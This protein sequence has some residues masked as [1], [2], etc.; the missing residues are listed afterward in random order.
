MRSVGSVRRRAA[1]TAGRVAWHA[2]APL[3]LAGLVSFGCP[4]GAP[5]SPEQPAG[6]RAG[7]G[8]ERTSPLASP[9]AAGSGDAAA[10]AASEA[11]APASPASAPV[12]VPPALPE[13]MA[14]LGYH[15]ATEVALAEFVPVPPGATGE[16]G[17]FGRGESTVRVA[18]VR[19]ANERF[20]GPHVRDLEERRLVLPT[21]G[22]AVLNAGRFVVH[23]EALD[24]ATADA[25]AAELRAAL[26]WA[27]PE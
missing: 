20:A 3:A 25:V 9:T 10:A 17:A 1:R 11:P 24:R 4:S 14:R 8:S 5:S 22:E 27:A 23:I 7:S 26:R 6:E 12:A 13:L 2:I 19:Y 21:S 15:D 16:A 18:L